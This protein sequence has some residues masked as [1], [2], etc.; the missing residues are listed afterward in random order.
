MSKPD[1]TAAAAARQNGIMDH[2]PTDARRRI[3]DACR[4][5]EER[6]EEDPPL[7]DVARAAHF[8]PFHF[9]RLF[10]GLTGETVRGYA[11]RLRL[12]RAAH[13]LVHGD[14]DI[15]RVALDSGYGSH[16]AFTR[17]FTKRFGATPSDYRA[18]RS[19]ALEPWRADAS[20]AIDVR[21]ERREPCA[22]ARVRH[23]GPYADVG[24][25]WGTLM[26]WGWSKMIFGKP[27]CFGLC[28]DD[29]D[30]TDPERVRYDACMVVKEGTRV[31]SGV[32]LHRHPGGLYAATLHRGPFGTIGETYARLFAHVVTRPIEGRQRVLGDPPSLEVYLDDPR[33]TDPERMR[34]E[35]WMPVT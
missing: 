27:A 7:E 19:E 2:D 32:E 17:A 29:P 12:E 28:Y 23:V 24:D 3:E 22:V 9:H 25:A 6:L 30:V 4:F 5:I 21:L 8:S 15:L 26:K 20:P 31:R 18:A 11:R 10:R 13:R 1:Q 34:T 16:E 14:D 35:I 33:R